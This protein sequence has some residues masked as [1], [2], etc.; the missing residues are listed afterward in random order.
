MKNIEPIW[1]QSILFQTLKELN[2]TEYEAM[3]EYEKY[4]ELTDDDLAA[5]SL[6]ERYFSKYYQKKTAKEMLSKYAEDI[7]KQI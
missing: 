2:Q 7:N 1:R 6:Y 3:C 4:H 5:K